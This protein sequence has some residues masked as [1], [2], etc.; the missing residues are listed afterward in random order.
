[1]T[2][3]RALDDSMNWQQD[4]ERRLRASYTAAGLGAAAVERR[5]DGVRDGIRDWTV[6]EI[7]DAETRVGHVVVTVADRNGT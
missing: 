2:E 1:M 3:F 4:F 7:T 5:I 6:A